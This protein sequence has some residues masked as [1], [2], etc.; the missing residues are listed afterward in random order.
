MNLLGTWQKLW[1]SKKPGEGKGENPGTAR[2]QATAN[3]GRN[4]PLRSK[5]GT[6]RHEVTAVMFCCRVVGADAVSC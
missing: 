1:N 3:T 4:N 6:L 2:N 5:T